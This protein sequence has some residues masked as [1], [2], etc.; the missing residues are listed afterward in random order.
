M[1]VY[2][3]CVCVCVCVRVCVGVWV[4]VCVYVCVCTHRQIC[5]HEKSEGK[6]NDNKRTETG[7]ISLGREWSGGHLK[8]MCTKFSNITVTT[9]T[10]FL[11]FALPVYYIIDEFNILST[12][13]PGR[14]SVL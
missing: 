3:L 13:S 10:R 8:R 11:L 12:P 4:C 5:A 7:S 6:C 1:C 2:M 9:P 14:S